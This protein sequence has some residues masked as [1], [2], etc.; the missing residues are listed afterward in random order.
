MNIVSAAAALYANS[1]IDTTDDVLQQIDAYTQANH[2]KAH[3]LSGALQ[4]NFLSILSKS[5]QPNYILEIGTF[6]GYSA[7]CLAKGLTINGQLHTIELRQQDATTAQQFFNQSLYNN[8]ITLHVGNAIDIIPTLPYKWDIVFI[9]ADKTGYIDYY[10]LILPQ[11]QPNGLIIV[12]NIL[13]HGQVLEADIKGKSAIA[14]NAFNQHVKNDDRTT[15]VILTVRDG[16]ML[17]KKK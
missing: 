2:P 17:I 11:L 9:D 6:T 16:L 4:G 3:M 1:F 14:I 12:D 13:F 15:Q 10:E 8:H 7:L 5:I